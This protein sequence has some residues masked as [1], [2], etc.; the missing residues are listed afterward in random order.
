MAAAVVPL[1][2]PLLAGVLMLLRRALA[3]VLPRTGTSL[4]PK[5]EQ[6]Y[7]DSYGAC[8]LLLLLAAGWAVR[9]SRPRTILSHSTTT[10]RSY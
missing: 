8:C 3:T 1:L 6:E 2:A 4:S 10:T 5:V 7:E 9:C